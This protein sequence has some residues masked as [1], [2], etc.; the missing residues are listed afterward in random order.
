MV[1]PNTISASCGV[2]HDRDGS[3]CPEDL[4]REA[5]QAMYSRKHGIVTGG[6]VTAMT[7]RALA[8]HRLAMDGMRG[9]YTVLQAIRDADDR[10]VDYEIVEANSIVRAAF[11]PVFGEAVGARHTALKPDSNTST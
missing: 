4:L 5:D 6:S 10:I 1:A 3:R 8:Y 2:V 7:S 11:E 9:S